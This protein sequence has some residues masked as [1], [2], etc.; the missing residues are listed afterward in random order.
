MKFGP[1]LFIVLTGLI[2]TLVI[3]TSLFAGR[4]LQRA[5]VPVSERAIASASSVILSTLSD[6]DYRSRL[7]LRPLTNDARVKGGLT[8]RAGV[9]DPEGL[10]GQTTE[11][12]RKN[13][14]DYFGSFVDEYWVDDSN[15]NPEQD[16]LLLV[17]VD[18]TLAYGE[19]GDGERVALGNEVMN[20]IQIST[21]LGAIAT[22][23]ESA[24]MLWSGP[25]LRSD[26]PIVAGLNGGL[27]LA[28]AS[29]VVFHSSG[30][31]GDEV[32]GAAVIATHRLELQRVVSTGADAV[33]TDRGVAID[34]TFR[35]TDGGAQSASELEQAA[36]QWLASK[37][38]PDAGPAA[39][40]LGGAAYYALPLTVA[41]MV[42][43]PVR[44]G[45]FYSRAAELETISSARLEL[46]EIGGAVALLAMAIAVGLS[47][48]LSRPI[49]EISAAARKVATG[50]LKVSVRADRKDEL[51]DLARRFNEMV[52]GLRERAVA[53]D[54]LGRYLSPEMAHD[55][56][57]G[58]K[59]I[60]LQGERRELTIL[61]CDVAG[62]TTISEKLEPEALVALL[63]QYLDAM[64][65]VLIKHGAYV[66]KFE[67]DAI[68]A[69]WNA[70][71]HAAD[72]AVHACHAILEMRAAAKKLS[73]EWTAAGQP[74]FGVRYGLN[75]GVAIVGNMGATDKINYTA[76][77]DNVN[78]ASRLEGANKQYGTELMI[79]EETFDHARE[80]IEARE[81]D[82]LKVQ[83]K[84]RPVRVYELLARV[85][86]LSAEQSKV[87]DL[88]TAGLKMYRE[89]RF[90]EA[91]ALFEQAV[92][93]GPSRTFAARCRRFL[94]QPPQADW[95]GT[96]EMETK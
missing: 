15:G 4:V 63:N 75:T 64:V 62:F 12:R 48:N 73:A 17:G 91:R 13:A 9:A 61:F 57:S 19:S 27:Y 51:G 8:A 2:L 42:D 41:G 65:K 72:H 29:R 30:V 50:D 34:S 70:P 24:R 54:A 92:D 59:G 31:G 78:L 68:M 32:V 53:K 66:D 69:F 81:L 22:G 18:G 37:P 93:D 74:A 60:S 33:F 36:A 5:Y 83:G 88:F 11:A 55:V 26:A 85:G 39:V 87:R 23:D 90:E 6:R 10:G 21:L 38:S 82:V 79:S 67:G 43:G 46:A 52:Q 20:H 35:L 47:R 84:R 28:A 58:E 77:G 76:I 40:M 45:V 95:D 94:E 89:R 49:N 44:G 56:V 80:Q 96:Y 3:L 1:K 25:R 16:L 86:E 7:L 71:R 14:D